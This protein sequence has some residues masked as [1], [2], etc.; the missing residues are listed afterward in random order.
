[1]VRSMRALSSRSAAAAALCFTPSGAVLHTQPPDLPS[2]AL[3]ELNTNAFATGGYRFV[4]RLVDEDGTVQGPVRRM[5]FPLGAPPNAKQI[6]LGHAVAKNADA[7]LHVQFGRG[8]ML[9][10]P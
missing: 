7:H 2:I 1:M 4:V 3:T 6:V 10:P 9:L 8:L 5:V